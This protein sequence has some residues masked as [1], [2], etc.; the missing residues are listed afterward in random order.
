MKRSLFR[1]SLIIPALIILITGCHN[2]KTAV[3]KGQE[4]AFCIPDSLI[5]QVRFDTVRVK[6]V[7]NELKLIGKITFDQD[8]VVR[9]FPLVSGFVTEVRV[10]LGSYVKKDQVL[11]IIKSSEYGDCRK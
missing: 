8:K 7:Y 10:S 5:S 2:K 9:I 4:S 1:L 11:A 3:L 6:K